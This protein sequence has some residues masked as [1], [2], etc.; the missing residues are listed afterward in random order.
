MSETRSAAPDTT[1]GTRRWWARAAFALAILAVAVPLVSA[2]LL[3]A[4]GSLLVGIGGVAVMV[5]ALYWFLASRGVLR[6]ISLAIAILSPIVV[7]VLF[8]RA[9][10]LAEVVASIVL[11][12]LTVPCARAALRGRTSDT[13]V[14]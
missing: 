3:S 2:G 12:L 10:L 7:L 9:H 1:T 14:R 6:W 13:A 4:V 5:A 8:I 11:A